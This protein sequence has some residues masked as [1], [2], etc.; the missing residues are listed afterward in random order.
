MNEEES[1]LISNEIHNNLDNIMTKYEKARI[2]GLRSLQ[3]GMNSKP[4]VDTNGETDSLRIA[5]MELRA[6]KLSMKIR[7]Y[8]P[9]G[10]HKD[11]SVKDLI[12]P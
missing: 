2:L 8:Y 4:L 1:V 7:R 10:S 9:N 6:G 5:L 3:L 11:V 12:I